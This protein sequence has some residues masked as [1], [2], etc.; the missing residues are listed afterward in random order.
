[1]LRKTTKDPRNNSKTEKKQRPT[2][3]KEKN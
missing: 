3:K 2:K 1:M